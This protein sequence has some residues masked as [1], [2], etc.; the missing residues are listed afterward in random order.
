MAKDLDQSSYTSDGG[1]DIVSN[2]DI[3]SAVRRHLGMAAHIPVTITDSPDHYGTG[4][5]RIQT[6]DIQADGVWAI[7]AHGGL[8]IDLG[9]LVTQG[10]PPAG[11]G[12]QASDA[13]IATAV[14]TL[15]KLPAWVDVTVTD[16]GKWALRTTD[17]AASGQWFVDGRNPD[18][19]PR[20]DALLV[21]FTTEDSPRFVP[22]TPDD[23]ISDD[24]VVEL[25]RRMKAASDS[26]QRIQSLVDDAMRRGDPDLLRQARDLLPHLGGNLLNLLTA[27]SL[28]IEHAER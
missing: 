17:T 27:M 23:D 12:D 8:A 2:A 21:E 4:E 14:R 26:W 28:T 16:E 5:W 18:G 24:D 10:L 15:L 1:G 7:K 13:D 6:T 25:E 3:V 22:K 9:E 11:P 20:I 19:S